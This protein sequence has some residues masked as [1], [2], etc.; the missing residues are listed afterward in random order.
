MNSIV[1]P[2]VVTLPSRQ[3]PL[4]FTYNCVTRARKNI[5][6]NFNAILKCSLASFRNFYFPWCIRS[7]TWLTENKTRQNEANNLHENK[8]IVV[9]VNLLKQSNF[10]SFR[11]VFSYT[12][13]DY[14]HNVTNFI[15]TSS[16]F[17]LCNFI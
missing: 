11:H 16:Y 13:I 3:C 12:S 15:R 4:R 6:R 10:R 9:V 8:F 7:L 14:N 2:F 1:E 17:V 5:S